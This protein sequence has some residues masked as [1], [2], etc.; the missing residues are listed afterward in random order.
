MRLSEKGR[1]ILS[2]VV[3]F[4]D[5]AF[6]P[7]MLYIVVSYLFNWS[8]SSRIFSTYIALIVALAWTVHM[9]IMDIFSLTRDIEHGEKSRDRGEASNRE[10]EGG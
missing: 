8:G 4:L 7:A 9:M 10:G 6:T 2:R 1:R 5:K 3:N